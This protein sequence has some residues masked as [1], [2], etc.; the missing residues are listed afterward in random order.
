MKIERTTTPSLP[1]TKSDLRTFA[2]LHTPDFDGELESLQYSAVQDIQ[3]LSHCKIGSA[4]YTVYAENF[5][6]LELPLS[7]FPITR[8]ASVTYLDVDGVEQTLTASE[9]VYDVTDYPQRLL[10][11]GDSL[12]SLADSTTAPINR[13]RI[14]LVAGYGD[15]G[16]GVPLEFMALP[17]NLA[18]AVK[19]LTLH[20]FLSKEPTG[21]ASMASEIPYGIKS[22]V[23]RQ[24]KRKVW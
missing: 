20:R 13:V 2:A 3:G 23:N 5:S 7:L 11:T 14:N 17:T 19:Q 9:Y 22:I 24:R 8:I 10:F 1:I 12:P 15:T 6:D 21:A 4:E 18:H 16:S